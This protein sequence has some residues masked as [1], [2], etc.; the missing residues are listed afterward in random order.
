MTVMPSGTDVADKAVSTEDASSGREVVRL[1]AVLAAL[2]ETKVE[3]MKASSALS[4]TKKS[5][6]APTSPRRPRLTSSSTASS[7]QNHQYSQ[8]HHH[9]HHHHQHQHQHQHHRSHHR[10][11]AD[12]SGSGEHQRREY[13]KHEAHRHR[14]HDSAPCGDYIEDP[15]SR[16]HR[17]QR[18]ADKTRRRRASEMPR[19]PR[20]KRRYSKSPNIL[21]DVN[22][23][24]DSRFELLDI[25]ADQD[26]AL[27]NFEKS[28]EA[29]GE[30][31]DHAG[32]HP[33]ACYFSHTA[34]HL[35]IHYD[36][37]DYVAVN[38]EDAFDDRVSLNASKK[39]DDKRERFHRPRRKRKRKKRIVEPDVPEEE[40]VDPE[41]LPPRARWTIVATACLLLAMSLL[42]VGVTLRMAPIIDDMV[43]KE[44]EELLNSLNRDNSVPENSTSL[45]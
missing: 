35:K 24:L 6:S 22:L 1:E 7:S 10:D 25:D 3:A 42:L 28:R 13:N 2:V 17:K 5:G 33:S 14:R 41:E 4:T 30:S 34:A 26:L 37:D 8:H 16:D 12:R 15:S 29:L 23:P 36:Q 18:S 31:C 40:Y 11:A 32:I 9:H 27:I 19:S 39:R 21:Q 43:R 44:N 20:K 45:P 38:L